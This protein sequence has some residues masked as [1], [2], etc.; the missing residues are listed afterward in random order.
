MTAK[1][2]KHRFAS[3]VADG[4]DATLV[5][6]S[7]WNDDHNFYLGINAQTNTS[8]TI[9]DTDA[10]TLITYNN[11][12]AVAVTL[13]QAGASAQFA[14]GHVTF[15]R[16]LGAGVVT[17][18]PA[19]S[20]I[21]GG[22]ILILRQ[23]EHAVIIS[24]GTNYTALVVN[25]FIAYA[26]GLINGTLVATVASNALT[27][28]VKTHAGND[29]SPSDPAFI[30]FRNATA[31]TGDFVVIPI[32][33]ALSHTAN[34][35]ATLGTANNVP[36]RIWV[37][38]HNN[39]GTV[40]LGLINCVIG[41]A[42]PTQIFPL[43]EGQL[44]ST[45]AGSANSAGG[46]YTE[47]DTI[48]SKAFRILGYVEYASGLATAGTWASTPTSIQLFGPG[49][50]KPGETVQVVYFTTAT[51]SS[52]T[53]TSVGASAVSAS[54][55]PTNAANLVAFNASANTGVDNSGNSTQPQMFRGSVAVGQNQ[56][57]ISTTGSVIRCGASFCGLD[58][59]GSTSAQ[60][61]AI[62]FNSNTSGQAAYCG[63]GMMV[64]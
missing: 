51:Q 11:A 43:D 12:A 24:D 44:V 59:P 50:H 54:I 19:T 41:G 63:P 46:F 31:A 14:S 22:A 40:R 56:Q 58:A 17:I 55:T 47:V 2:L 25:R 4:A 27:V 49:V 36:F 30:V 53:S 29:P 26:T 34:S 7:N 20:T 8:Y 64:L 62:K 16:N 45:S 13:P 35:T 1:S 10:W 5:R 60:T 48:T 28:A 21:N 32:I 33:A 61:Y 3:A 15:H 42:A 39:A 9:A 38:A 37:T 52:T 57:T 23:Y 6:P 18:T